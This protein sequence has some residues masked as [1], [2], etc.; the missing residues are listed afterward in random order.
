MTM[1]RFYIFPLL[2]LLLLVGCDDSSNDVDL[3]S[4]LTLDVVKPIEIDSEPGTTEIWFVTN[5][6]WSAE[7]ES[8]EGGMTIEPTSGSYGTNKITVTADEYTGYESRSTVVKITAGGISKTVE[9]IQNTGIYLLDI[10]EESITFEPEGGSIEIDLDYNMNYIIER[11]DTLAADWLLTPETKVYGS[12]VII[13]SA[14]ANPMGE[15]RETMVYVYSE[16]YKYA[17]SVIVYQKANNLMELSG[18]DF[19]AAVEGE[20]FNVTYPVVEGAVYEFTTCP[21]W[22]EV[23]MST[24]SQTEDVEIDGVMTPTTT[25][26]GNIEFIVPENTTNAARSDKA[27]LAMTVVLE[28]ATSTTPEVTETSYQDIYFSQAQNDVL[29]YGYVAYNSTTGAADTISIAFTANVDYTVTVDE[30]A[31]DWMSVGEFE[32]GYINLV[33]AA[34]DTGLDRQDSITVSAVDH[35]MSFRV[36]IIQSKRFLIES[37]NTDTELAPHVNGETYEITLAHNLYPDWEI[38]TNWISFELIN[39]EFEE[40]EAPEKESEFEEFYRM[41]VEPYE[42]DGKFYREGSVIVSY[43]TSENILTFNVSQSYIV[44]N[45]TA[46]GLDALLTDTYDEGY[47]TILRALAISGELNAADLAKI[48]SITS[49][50]GLDLSEATIVGDITVDADGTVASGNAIPYAWLKDHSAIESVVLPDE[51]TIIGESAFEGC[52]VTEAIA[53]PNLV[54]SI[55]DAAFRN[56]SNM[57]GDVSFSTS[58]ITVGTEAYYNCSKVTGALYFS[59]T[60]T[61]IGERAF[62]N[63]SSADGMLKLSRNMPVIKESTFE[64]CTSLAGGLYIPSCV[65]DIEKNAFKNCSGFTGELTISYPLNK[66]RESAFEGCS[67]MTGSLII[68]STVDTIGVA[69][70]MGCESFTAVN[71]AS[72]ALTFIDEKVFANCT[73]FTGTLSIPT[74]ITEIRDYAFYRC[75]SMTGK[76]SLHSRM[77]TVGNYAFYGCKSLT[78]AFA[79]PV[80][81]ESVGKAA[82]A[83]CYKMTGA[84]TIP[85]TNLTYLSDEMFAYTALSGSIT[86]PDG[87]IT[88]GENAIGGTNHAGKL[89]IPESVQEIG[90]QSYGLLITSLHLNWTSNIPADITNILIELRDQFDS[91]NANFNSESEQHIIYIP[92]GYKGFYEANFPKPTETEAYLFEEYIIEA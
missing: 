4:E 49:I 69:A 2:C 77:M 67:A 50:E 51:V 65:T 3:V 90:S 28:E 7:I 20:T 66:I 45:T 88:V 33:L 44:D 38:T 12:D 5:Y 19:E 60:V 48:A 58:L 71:V 52:N 26:I 42:Y 29:E 22:I 85:T 32:F 36:A 55:G 30:T 1:K 35:D 8:T 40:G 81:L 10:A 54:T 63:C 11:A 16:N 34:N 13:L 73:S 46:G 25:T 64:G 87:L 39:W 86:L 82:F 24:S 41:V 78:G 27:V 47:E 91:N 9:I 53:I 14:E 83:H 70:F 89:Y 57:S 75:E 79:T 61:E 84:L 56:C 31:A 21:S 59:N 6:E 76:L 72:S 18:S 92:E 43:G 74:T 62:Y 37:V 23:T 80:L 68:P 17:D 15:M